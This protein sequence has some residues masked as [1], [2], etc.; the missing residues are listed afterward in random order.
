MEFKRNSKRSEIRLRCPCRLLDGVPL[1][2]EL[3]DL[4]VSGCRARSVGFPLY[5]GQ[6]LRLFPEGGDAFTATVRRS[7]GDVS[8]IEFDADL[9]HTVFERMRSYTPDPEEQREQDPASEATSEPGQPEPATPALDPEP[10]SRVT[11][12]SYGSLLDT[13]KAKPRKKMTAI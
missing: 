10:V 2:I 13:A 12:Q 11:A 1:E 3:L 4:S 7:E 8:G 6:A 9:P 5:V